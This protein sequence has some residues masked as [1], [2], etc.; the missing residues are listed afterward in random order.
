MAS[1]VQQIQ[2]VLASASPR[3]RELLGHLAVPFEAMSADVDER[4][5]PSET[6]LAYVER[7]ACQKAAVAAAA[8][9][10]ALVLAADT[11]V[12]LGAEILGKPRDPA[13]A[14]AMLRRLSGRPHTVLTGIAVA[15]RARASRVV[16]TTVHFRVLGEPEI[17]W[18]VATGEGADK[19]GAY[20]VQGIGGLF[21]RALFG[22]ASN[23]VGLPLAETAELLEQ[24]GLP[25]P[26][27]PV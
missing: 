26:W 13:E 3:R 20:A 27:S 21:V 2:L 1:L 6:P 23:V 7:L 14:A 4:T 18:Y 25:M 5:E 10:G 11:A 12:V 22:S 16:E 9:P 8:R 19:A 17:A 24:A 15:G